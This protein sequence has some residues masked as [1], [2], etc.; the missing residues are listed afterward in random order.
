MLGYFNN[1]EATREVLDNEGWF[2]TGDI[3][4]FDEDDFLFI[5][6]R[7]KDLIVTAGGK[8]IAPQ[9]LE[10]RFRADRFVAQIVV[11]GDRR[12]FLSAL[13]VPD[14]DALNDWAKTNGI[15]GSPAELIH[16]PETRELFE[17]LVE[18]INLDFPG[19]SQVKKFELLEREF[20]LEDGELTPTLKVK[21]FA[22]ARNFDKVISAM[23]PEA[24]P[25]EED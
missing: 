4:H 5:T 8:N 1:E 15:Q 3:G 23:Y 9:P 18:K 24:L 10:N 13:I 7:K 14:F 11:I 17:Q 22:I 2:S 21:R 6:D 19:F 16:K 20:T 25:G 12:Q